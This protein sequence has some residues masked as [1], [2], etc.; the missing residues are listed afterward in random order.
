[1]DEKIVFQ[2]SSSKGKNLIIRYP[3][4]HDA[5][6]MCEYINTLS[7]ER[8]F[9]RFQGE[10]VSLDEEEKYLREQLEKIK[11]RKAILLL[12]FCNNKL[13]GVSR[14]DMEDRTSRHV[15][16][17]GISVAKDFRGEGIGKILME[18]VLEEAEKT[19]RDLKI[20]TLGVFSSHPMAIKMYKTFGF[21]EYGVLPGG[22]FRNNTY[23]DHICMF[24]KI[25]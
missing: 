20:I 6:A 1:M 5:A 24:K 8:T 25:K 11:N 4:N 12:T 10:Q 22:I 14:V 19:L 3:N 18:K 2:G 16:T 13:I 9:I 7:I 21:Q 15:G 23:E 17:F